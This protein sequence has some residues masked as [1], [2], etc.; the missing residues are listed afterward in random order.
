M[1]TKK[2]ERT[3]KDLLR[4]LMQYVPLYIGFFAVLFKLTWF[5]S[6]T[7]EEAAFLFIGGIFL[8]FVLLLIGMER[9]HHLLDES[10]LKLETEQFEAAR[11]QRSDEFR[12]ERQE[13]ETERQL[14]EEERQEL[15]AERQRLE[16]YAEEARKQDEAIWHKWRDECEARWEK[17]VAKCEASLEESETRHQKDLAAWQESNA[18]WEEAVEACEAQIRL[19]QESLQESE[20][21][22]RALREKL[23]KYEEI[24]DTGNDV[25][26]YHEHKAERLK[27]EMAQEIEQLKQELGETRDRV[28][29][30]QMKLDQS[31]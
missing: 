29:I 30:L 11:Q 3:G 19:L 21:E 2:P 14:L 26:A 7:V 22:N 1:E 23:Q 25:T 16:T 20:N 4:E 8:T 24:V 12:T 13:L 31:K 15:E 27:Q 10:R 28:D 5:P 9:D 17:W 18:K 6:I